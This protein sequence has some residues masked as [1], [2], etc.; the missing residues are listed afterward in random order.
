[1]PKNRVLLEMQNSVASST[2]GLVFIA[3]DLFGGN[4]YT[5]FPDTYRYMEQIY[6]VA[7]PAYFWGVIYLA[8]GITHL[9]ALKLDA[10]TL[11]KQILWIKSGLWLF[12]GLCVINGDLY[13]WAGW[14]SLLFGIFAATCFLKL[15]KHTDA[16][17]DVSISPDVQDAS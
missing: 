8:A 13:A 5:R 11:R 6:G 2:V 15:R 12:L 14:V 1:M 16:Y 4:L 10:R 9:V 3:N 7:L 17:Y